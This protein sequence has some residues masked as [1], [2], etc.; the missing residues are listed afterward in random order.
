MHS[1]I[2]QSDSDVSIPLRHTST[3][4]TAARTEES[5]D[6]ASES[7]ISDAVGEPLAG[8]PRSVN[9]DVPSNVGDTDEEIEEEVS[10]LLSASGSC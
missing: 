3:S 4:H 1:T 2:D 9:L 10:G 6:Y 5:L 8:S 7:G